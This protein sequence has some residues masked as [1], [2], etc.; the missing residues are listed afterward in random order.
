MPY[1]IVHKLETDETIEMFMNAC[2]VGDFDA[3]RQLFFHAKV[4][5][6]TVQFGSTAIHY[7]AYHGQ[8]K[9][10]CWLI[11]R[12]SHVDENNSKGQTARMVVQKWLT[13]HVLGT[14]E[15]L[16]T[17]DL[18]DA[19]ITTWAV[20]LRAETGWRPIFYN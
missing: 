17:P 6:G 8:Y 2:S 16:I 5:V 18:K 3:I 10:V 19:M 11:E 20:L 7:A 9:V 1:S 13:K 4:N 14:S 12:G 15:Y